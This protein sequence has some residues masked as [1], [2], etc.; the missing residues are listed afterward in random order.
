MNYNREQFEQYASQ[1]GHKD[2]E[3]NEFG[4]YLRAYAA[5]TAAP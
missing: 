3:Q 1:M 4:D 2:F 5:Q